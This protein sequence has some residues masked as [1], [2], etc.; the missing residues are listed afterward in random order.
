M[1]AT[2]APDTATDK[3]V[4]WSSNATD[5]ATVDANGKVTAVKPGTATITAA[6]DNG[7]TATCE[8]TVKPN[9]YI[10]V[11]EKDGTTAAGEYG[12]YSLSG[13]SKIVVMDVAL[14]AENGL[15]QVNLI[16][17]NQNNVDTTLFK[18][19]AYEDGTDKKYGISRLIGSSWVKG[20]VELSKDEWTEIRI[21]LKCD[22]SSDNVILYTF[23]GE[24]YKLEGTRTVN[25]TA[26]PKRLKFETTGI[27]GAS[28][29]L[30][31]YSVY[32]TLDTDYT[33][34]T[35]PEIDVIYKQDYN[36]Y[37]AHDTED[38]P[39]KI[40]GTSGVR[41]GINISHVSEPLTEADN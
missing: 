4:T 24:N 19:E 35:L 9:G 5:V 16:T 26:L 22:G 32:T 29:H 18:L 10:T 12:T 33:S 13:N 8:V 3:T 30:D 20:C 15:G 7:K 41:R 14:R 17:R 11:T 2:V 27:N 31:N 25:L 39:A 6:T 38:C 1:T 21:V 37:C 40:N 34:A 36:A 28:L 23:N